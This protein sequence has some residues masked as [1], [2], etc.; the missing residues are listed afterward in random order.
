MGNATDMPELEIDVSP[1][2]MNGF[3][4]LLPSGDLRLRVDTRR[5][6]IAIPRGGDRGRFRNDQAS[7]C[8]LGV[9]LNVEFIGHIPLGCTTTRERCHEDAVWQCKWPELDRGEEIG[10]HGKCFG[11][12]PVRLIGKGRGEMW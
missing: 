11:L 2:R 9:I 10:R 7:R 6:G 12:E 3:R 8:A 1:L 4:H 5:V